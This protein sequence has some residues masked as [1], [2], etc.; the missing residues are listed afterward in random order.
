[1]QYKSLPS[2]EVKKVTKSKKSHKKSQKVTKSHKNSQ[3]KPAKPKLLNSRRKK[4]LASHKIV[5]NG[6]ICDRHNVTDFVI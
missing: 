5:T 6:Q 4:L 2:Q 3:K 1:L